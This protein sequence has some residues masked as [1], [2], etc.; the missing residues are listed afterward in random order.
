MIIVTWWR[1]GCN[2]KRNMTAY[3]TPSLYIYCKVESHPSSN[4]V[5]PQF[6]SHIRTASG[7]YNIY[8]LGIKDSTL[9][10]SSSNIKHAYHY[11]KHHMR[12]HWH[13]CNC[14][15]HTCRYGP[16]SHWYKC[17]NL[18]AH[19][20]Y[21]PLAIFSPFIDFKWA[22]NGQVLQTSLQRQQLTCLNGDLNGLM[23][24]GLTQ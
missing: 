8:M 17:W 23:K 15:F 13:V 9:V 24:K 3:F 14:P 2:L 21:V 4:A 19:V 6:N 1:V 20:V 16:T 5:K 18:F 10:T 12:F 7:M 11:K 22:L